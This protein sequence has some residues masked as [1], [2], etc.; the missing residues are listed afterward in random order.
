[1]PGIRDAP[2]ERSRDLFGAA[3]WILKADLENPHRLGR[4]FHEGMN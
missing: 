1:M 2:V 4:I 3:A